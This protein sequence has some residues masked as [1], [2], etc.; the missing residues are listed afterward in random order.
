MRTLAIALALC[1]CAFGQDT[2]AILEGQVTDPSGS[3]IAGASVRAVSTQTGYARAQLTTNAGAY[4][5]SL[6]AG[7]YDLRVTA[8]NFADY[9]RSGVE[10]AVSQSVRV[11]VQLSVSKAKDVVNVTGAA[12]LVDSSSNVI[13]NVVTGRELLDLPLNGRNFTQLGLLQPGVAPMTAGLAEAG[14]SLRA[15]QAY[16]VDGQRPESNNYLLDGV[17]NVNRVDGG[18]SLRTPVDAIQEFRILTETAPAEYGG[19]SGATTTVV[20]RSGGNELHGTLYEFL[21]NDDLDSRNFFA[22]R[23]EPLKQ[24]QFG[25]TLGGP[26]RRNRDFLFGYYEGFRNVQGVTQNATVPSDAERVGD[27]SG[28]TDPQTGQPIPL[29]NEF[30]GQPFPNNQVP[31]FMQNATALKLVNFFPH[32]NAGPNL[33]TTTQTMRNRAD[34][35]GARFDHIFSER[36]Q[37]SAHYARA[38]SA[39]V[40]PLS[41]A[42][43]NVPGFP[44]GEDIGTQT[45]SVSET[46]L[47]SGTTINILH[48]GFFRNVFDTDKPLN[49][50]SPRDLGFNYDSTLAAAQGPP[51]FIVSGY[52]S[53]GDPITGPRNTAQNTFEATDSLAHIAGAHSFRLGG[54]FR[55][56]QVNMTEGIASNG[57]FVFA[58]FPASD[59]F[60]SFLL[61]FPVVF[62][63]GGG[64]MNRGLRNIDFAV[65][66]QDEWRVTPHLTLNYGLRWEV[67]TPFVDI[68]DRMNSWSPGQQSKVFPNAPEGLL[69]PGDPGVPRGIAPVYWKGLMPRVGLAWDPTGS[70]KTSIR[71]A[72]G[73]FYDSFTNGVGGPLQAPLSAL[74]WT[75]ARQLSPPINFTDP[76]NGAYPFSLNSFPQPTT[77]LTVENGMRPPYAQN[78]NL[79][80]QRSLS[81]N[82]LLDVRYIGNKGTRL[83]RMIEGNPAIYGPGATSNN[84]DQRRQYAGCHGAQGPCDF[85]S[86]GLITDSTNSTY[87]AGQ[88]ALSR[89]FSNGLGFLAS[90]TFSKSLD[91]VSSFNVAGSAPRLVAGENDLAQNPFDLNAEHGPSLFDARH[92]FVFSGSY[93]IPFP[94]SAAPFARAAFAGW[95]INTIANF[96]SG[97]PFTV[98][99]SANVALQ[100]SS[101]EITGFYSSRPNLI[102]DPNQGPHTASQWVSRAAFQRLDPVSQAGQFGNEGRNVVRG[103]AISNVDLSL[104]KTFGVTERVR[105]QFR[106]ECFNLA[107]HANFGLP[108]NDIASPTFG[109]VLEAGPPRL[110]QFGVK[111]IY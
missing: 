3:V 78:W 6:P 108:D 58:P 94:R 51:F 61:G 26:I 2:S 34:Q 75:Q 60:A 102:A 80:V 91:Y 49:H 76:W 109:Q 7:Q 30:A 40:N 105:L 77:V 100:G 98:Y 106:A 19:T 67:S 101:P 13:G 43:A 90:Y 50:T 96:A 53:V 36:D 82:F 23:V 65:Y 4:H 44:V 37:L 103:P 38:A 25:A 92:R 59:S 31:G 14:G 46:H 68:R 104:L 74:P 10:L 93:E 72:Y 41:V 22:S 69:F 99:D 71:A 64:D 18:Y 63:Q 73:I 27:F 35:G 87:E 1:A 45:F 20:T 29:I 21:R 55:R 95:Q 81:N 9:V 12:P 11:D 16:A 111:L 57:F 107:N 88:I 110:L 52:A 42:G 86:V 48:A 15:G 83:P 56:N 39:N 5:L 62:F 47:F 17:T 70:G 28:L 84:A 85:A 66:A 79:S 97:T 89:R 24:N 32:A 54:D 33:F 8:A